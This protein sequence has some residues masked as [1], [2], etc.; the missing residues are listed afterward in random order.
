MRVSAS[1]V[2]DIVLQRDFTPQA[3]LVNRGDIDCQNGKWIPTL[4]RHVQLV[5][6]RLWRYLQKSTL[7]FV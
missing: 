6:R 1:R 4:P 2:R 5:A 7:K 3:S